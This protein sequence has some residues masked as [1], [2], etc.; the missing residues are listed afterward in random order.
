MFIDLGE[1]YFSVVIVY[2]MGHGNFLIFRL[3]IPRSRLDAAAKLQKSGV[4][5]SSSGSQWSKSEIL[6]QDAALKLRQVK[7]FDS[8]S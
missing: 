6:S 5:A 2:N 3:L 8:Q 4:H 7:T 1:Y